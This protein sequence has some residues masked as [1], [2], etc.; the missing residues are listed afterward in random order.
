MKINLT[1]NQKKRILNG[2]TGHARAIE[3]IAATLLTRVTLSNADGYWGSWSTGPN[4][5]YIE[6]N[7]VKYYI[8]ARHSFGQ[9]W[10]RPYAIPNAKYVWRKLSTRM[11]AHR[12][13]NELGI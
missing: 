1:D 13:C 10:V 2:I 5:N 6:I 7:G 12:M 9:I 4:S 11:D 8:S 3:P